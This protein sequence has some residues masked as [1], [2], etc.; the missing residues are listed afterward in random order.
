MGMF[1]VL[2]D[3][4]PENYRDK[5]IYNSIKYE[6]FD[7]FTLESGIQCFAGHAP[8]RPTRASVGSR[9]IR[10]SLGPHTDRTG[11]NK[12]SHPRGDFTNR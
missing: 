6:I 9:A 3:A 10:L 4:G 5:N 12:A 2:G 8:T 7:E 1:P 11:P